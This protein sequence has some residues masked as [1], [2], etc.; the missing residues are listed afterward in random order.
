[1]PHSI[2]Q[3]GCALAAGAVR[4]A[5]TP[6]A[7]VETALGLA[8]VGAIAA[9]SFARLPLALAAIG[10]VRGTTVG[11]CLAVSFGPVRGLAI[12]ARLLLTLAAVAALRRVIV[13][14]LSSAVLR[15]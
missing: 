12:P 8:A 11:R 15:R 10:A 7:A 2:E 5:R 14:A 4:A 1:V 9:A 6:T 3:A 13:A